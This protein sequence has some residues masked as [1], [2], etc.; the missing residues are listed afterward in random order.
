[1]DGDTGQRETAVEETDSRIWNQIYRQIIHTYLIED[2]ISR[3]YK[4]EKACAE[5]TPAGLSCSN[6][7]VV[8]NIRTGHLQS[9]GW[10]SRQKQTKRADLLQV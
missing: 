1:M 7:H 6:S 5:K 10:D 4:G 8:T 3:C 9:L 2:Y